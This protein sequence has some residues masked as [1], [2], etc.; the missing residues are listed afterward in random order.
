MK[1]LVFNFAY[2]LSI[3]PGVFDQVPVTQTRVSIVQLT[4]LDQYATNGGVGKY[5]L[6][7]ET[8]YYSRS[9]SI[10]IRR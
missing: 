5:F 8:N 4:P 7:Y 10:R 2:Q 9:G 1:E 6:K 3:I